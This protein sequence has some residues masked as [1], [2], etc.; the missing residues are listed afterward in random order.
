MNAR[1]SAPEAVRYSPDRG[2]RAW[3]ARTLGM[4]RTNLHA[5]IDTTHVGA[6]LHAQAA[7]IGASPLL[8]HSFGCGLRE[9]GIF[10]VALGP[11]P[12]RTV[13]YAC[14]LGPARALNLPASRYA[15]LRTVREKRAN[16]AL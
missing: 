15:S 11:S 10:C 12:R 3:A 13:K 9:A 7:R 8:S 4:E 2:C 16:I 5:G 6:P 14:G 1:P